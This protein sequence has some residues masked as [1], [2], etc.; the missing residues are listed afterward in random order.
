[1]SEQNQDAGKKHRPTKQGGNREQKNQERK[2]R[3][4]ELAQRDDTGIVSRMASETNDAI[5]LLTQNDFIVSRVRGS[6]GRPGKL[7]A[8]EA[9]VFL[10]RNEG[11]RQEMNL[12]N[13]EMAKKLGISYRPPRGYE[14]IV[15]TTESVPV[16][17]PEKKKEKEAATT[18]SL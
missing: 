1:M 7:S 9:L 6:F 16:G 3:K 4:L 17:A 11:L 15:A 2:Q 14:R 13:V 5:Y 12:L 18:V 8:Q 10:E